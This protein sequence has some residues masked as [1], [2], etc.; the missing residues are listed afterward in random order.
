MSRPLLA[1]AL[2]ALAAPAAAEAPRV[3]ADIAPVHSLVARVMQGVGEPALLVPPG[4]SPHFHALRP[5][6]AQA[7]QAAQIVVT[8]GP[9][10]APWLDRP[11]ATLAGTATR[12]DLLHS[13]GTTV[14]PTR[15]SALFEAHSHDD[16]AAPDDHDDHDHDHDGHD[17]GGSHDQ[18]ATDPHAWLDPE[19]GKLWL[20]IIAAALAEADPDNAALYRANATEG[21][22]EIDAATADTSAEVAPLDG[23]RY[24]VFHDAYQYF[25]NRFGLPAAG[26]IAISDASPPGPARIAELRERTAKMGVTCALTE[27]QFD[28]DLIATVF[29]GR[30]VAT[31]V[32]DP[33]G[34]QIPPGPQMYPALIRS[35]GAALAGC[36]AD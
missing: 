31:A 24:V 9:E 21:A 22:A 25:E 10:L 11:L 28:P 18:G 33:I 19:N 30:N 2:A 20:N 6:D 1:L 7:L 15:S 12:I 26:A 23:L 32:L 3:V 17:D 5:S 16:H 29:Q 36:A 27:P 8:V 4:A 35:I 34:A 14:L 13:P